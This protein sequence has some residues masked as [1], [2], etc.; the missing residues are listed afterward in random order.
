M[1]KL[2]VGCAI[3]GTDLLL[4]GFPIVDALGYRLYGALFGVSLLLCLIAFALGLVNFIRSQGKLGM[5]GAI[6]GAVTLTVEALMLV[7]AWVPVAV[8][9]VYPMVGA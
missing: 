4:L 6:M 5:L 2:S 8:P 7:Y 3:V 9:V 1:G